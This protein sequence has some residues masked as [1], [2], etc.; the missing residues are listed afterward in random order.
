MFRFVLW[1]TP[2]VGNH[3][4]ERTLF[5]GLNQQLMTADHVGQGQTFRIEVNSIC[6]DEGVLLEYGNARMRENSPNFS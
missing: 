6:V 3:T 5:E 4:T 1:L 2:N